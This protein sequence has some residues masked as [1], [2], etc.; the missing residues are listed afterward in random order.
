[1]FWQIDFSCRKEY[2]SNTTVYD[3]LPQV[4]ACDSIHAI[5][6]QFTPIEYQY[7]NGVLCK[8]EKYYFNSNWLT[9]EGFY[10]D[11]LINSIGCDSIVVL[12]LE[13]EDCPPKDAC[14]RIYMP[15]AFTP[16][17]D[18]VNDGFRPV[19]KSDLIKLDKIIIYNRWGELVFDSEESL[20]FTWS[21]QTSK[22][23][24]QMGVY[25]YSVRYTCSGER[26]LL[27]GNVTLLK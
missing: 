7:I 3:T 6:L 13:L 10:R 22:K 24:M 25:A 5:Q 17:G 4:N 11:T 2:W 12:N 15:T 18:G 14:N 16:N 8:G 21:H 1:M 9:E 27:T 23:D 20:S 26:K 19:L